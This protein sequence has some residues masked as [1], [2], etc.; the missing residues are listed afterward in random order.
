M[1]AH[2]SY[3]S[4]NSRA[5]TFG[6]SVRHD[7]DFKIETTT[8]LIS[9]NDLFTTEGTLENQIT[10]ILDDSGQIFQSFNP[11][12]SAVEDELHQ[13]TQCI[14]KD[15]DLNFTEKIETSEETASSLNFLKLETVLG[16]NI[17]SS[18]K[19][20]DK[21]NDSSLFNSP[22]RE[23]LSF[24]LPEWKNQD[25]GELWE[26]IG[27]EDSPN[28]Q[29]LDVENKTDN[30]LRD[31][32]LDLFNDKDDYIKLAPV[33]F[34]L[35]LVTSSSIDS[36]SKIA[37]EWEGLQNEYSKPRDDSVDA[38]K[39][40]IYKSV[41]NLFSDSDSANHL[42]ISGT[43]THIVEQ[44]QKHQIVDKNSEKH[45]MHVPSSV[46]T[47]RIVPKIAPAAEAPS[48]TT[49]FDPQ[50]T[51]I[52]DQKPQVLSTR[53]DDSQ[54]AQ[55]DP[56]VL[57]SKIEIKSLIVDTGKFEKR[58]EPKFVQ[59]PKKEVSNVHDASLNYSSKLKKV[60]FGVI[61]YAYI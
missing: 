39:K 54:K 12:L 5:P 52:F 10:T 23:E 6:S 41:S 7:P 27:N 60:T 38:K 30:A 40:V 50:T 33:D 3:I 26:L 29:N 61:L 59:L 46:E 1:G 11:F 56:S 36:L 58:E 32:K 31:Q 47:T 24:Q 48:E 45:E 14:T 44:P 13:N 4:E 2:L 16:H 42:P 20:T 53:L 51:S 21:S 15:G 55:I 37:S 57:K 18:V 8:N 34:Q 43:I 28:C 35:N 17:D 19:I 25:F 49:A 22:K 9:D